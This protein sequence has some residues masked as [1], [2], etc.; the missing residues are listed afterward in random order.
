L[1]S[2]IYRV[3]KSNFHVIKN[4]YVDVDEINIILCTSRYIEM[5]EDDEIDLDFNEKDDVRHD[6]KNEE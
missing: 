5:D 1:S 6:D 2:S 3:R 4:T